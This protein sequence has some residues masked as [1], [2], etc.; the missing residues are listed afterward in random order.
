MQQLR[1]FLRSTPARIG[2]RLKEIVDI[3]AASLPTAGV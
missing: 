3:A 2:R 1:S